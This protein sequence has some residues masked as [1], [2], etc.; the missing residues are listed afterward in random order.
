[1]T[2]NLVPALLVDS[3]Y[4]KFHHFLCWINQ[5]YESIIIAVSLTAVTLESAV[6]CKTFQPCSS[7][8]QKTSYIEETTLGS[9]E[10]IF[11][12][13]LQQQQKHTKRKY[14]IAVLLL[15]IYYPLCIT[16]VKFKSVLVTGDWWL[17]T[18]N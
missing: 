6:S 10:I 7:L 2:C 8:L 18:G 14:H 1:M 5:G 9:I 13:M 16:G 11:Q 3:I 15:P 12:R 17:V 4:H